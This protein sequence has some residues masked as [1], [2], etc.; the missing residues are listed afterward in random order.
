MTRCHHYRV[1]EW[2]L[3]GKIMMVALCASARLL[4]FWRLAPEK[5]D[6]HLIC[7]L[8]NT[9]VGT[10]LLYLG[11]PE[12]P[13]WIIA[14]EKVRKRHIHNTVFDRNC[15]YLVYDGLLCP[16][17]IMHIRCAKAVSVIQPDKSFN[18]EYQDM[19]LEQTM[20]SVRLNHH[21]FPSIDSWT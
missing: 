14:S 16:D 19:E 17:C 9:R 6:R 11:I 5:E 10:L 7:F 18:G 15:K 1:F 2:G 3:Q 8:F 4:S 13:P 20:A 21:P 12:T